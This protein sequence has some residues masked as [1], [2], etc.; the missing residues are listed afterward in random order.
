MMSDHPSFGDDEEERGSTAQYRLYFLDPIGCISGGPY[1]FEAANDELA[2][3]VAEAWLE[4]RG[5]ELWCGSRKMKTWP[6]I[7]LPF[8]RR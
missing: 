1:E 8:V 7:P 4:G 6:V 2:E 3:R 5:A